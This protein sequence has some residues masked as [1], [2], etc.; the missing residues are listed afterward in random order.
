MTITSIFSL[1]IA[2]V[3]LAVI[4]GPGVFTVVARSIASGFSHGLVTT[5]GIVCGDYVFIILSL[6]GL[7]TL[8][9]SM[10][11]LFTFLKYAGA[12]YLCWLGFKLLTA[13]HTTEEIQ[14]VYELSFLSNF[15]SGLV[16]T[17]GNPK[18]ILFYVSFFPAFINVQSVSIVEVGGLLLIATCS[19]GS[20]MIV[21]AFVASKTSKLFQSYR[22]S[23]ALNITAGSMMI[24]SGVLL[25]ASEI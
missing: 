3:V 19:V 13:K 9:D 17:L 14:P 24:G 5:L 15:I 10:G 18:A 2:M 20:V 11:G 12:I 1:F 6:Y 16:T 8:A 23:K 22:V 7:S 21:Y 25:A 4:P